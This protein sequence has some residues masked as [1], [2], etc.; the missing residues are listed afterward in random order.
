MNTYE[1]FEVLDRVRIWD[2]E[3]RIDL[4]RRILETVPVASPLPP[5]SAQTTSLDD[6]IN[7]LETAPPP[8]T[9]EECTKAIRLL[10]GE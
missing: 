10:K 3:T 2:V 1:M 7:F 8:S 6:A 9:D 4:A 5:K